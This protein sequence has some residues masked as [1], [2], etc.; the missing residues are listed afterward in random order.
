MTSALVV[1]DSAAFQSI[2]RIAL[3]YA[4]YKVDVA[5]NSDSALQQITNKTYDLLFIELNMPGSE[6]NV[7]LQAMRD[8]LEDRAYV[9]GLTANPYIVVEKN[10]GWIDFAILKPLD[11]Q[12]ITLFAQLLIETRGNVSP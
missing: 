12:D 1:D 7:V 8:R 2:I 9:I 4:G 10:Y 11:A 3:E 5:S 6:S